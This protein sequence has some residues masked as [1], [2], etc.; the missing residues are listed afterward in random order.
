MMG[1]AGLSLGFGHQVSGMKSLTHVH[2]GQR[3]ITRMA[4]GTG[5]ASGDVAPAARPGHL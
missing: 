4:A 3:T 2:A 5:A 1:G